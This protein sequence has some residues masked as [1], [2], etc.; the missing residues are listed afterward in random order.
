MDE[1]DSPILTILG[2]SYRMGTMGIADIGDFNKFDSPDKLLAHA[3]LSP[4]TYQSG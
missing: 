2:I 4:S 3:G 1:T